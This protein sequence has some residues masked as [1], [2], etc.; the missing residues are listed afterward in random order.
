MSAFGSSFN[1]PKFQDLLAADYSNSGQRVS[2]L[3]SNQGAG[4]IEEMVGYARWMGFMRPNRYCVLFQ[5][6]PSAA[7]LM[8]TKNERLSMNC[9]SATIPDSGFS[10][11][12]MSISGPKRNIPQSQVFSSDPAFQFNCGTDLYEYTFFRAWQRSIVD[13]VSR[14]AAYYND[15]ARNCSLTLVILPNNVK[16]FREMLDRLD[17]GELYGIR[18]NELY[19]KVV[20][21]N[22]VQHSSSNNVLISNVTFGYR[23]IVPYKDWAD[24]Y[25]YALKAA[26]DSMMDSIQSGTFTK[27]K[28]L[29]GEGLQKELENSA[30]EQ[31]MGNFLAKEPLGAKIAGGN[32]NYEKYIVPSKDPSTPPNAGSANVFMNNLLTSGI[33][34]SALFKGI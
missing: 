15:Y 27:A 25:K 20:G 2:P 9:L 21:M 8:E 26:A 4:F 31:S 16:N 13:P 17:T 11:A 10:T 6:V 12:E 32:P 29:S 24:D 3:G 18:L 7:A 22:Q 14:Q 23:E 34:T 19:P 30:Y 1:F 5:G 33:N 28:A